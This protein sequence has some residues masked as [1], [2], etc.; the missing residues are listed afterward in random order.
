MEYE[1]V[2]GK[3]KHYSTRYY[4][5]FVGGQIVVSTRKRDLPRVDIHFRVSSRRTRKVVVGCPKHNRAELQYIGVS[6][7]FFDAM[8]AAKDCEEYNLLVRLFWAWPAAG[9]AILR[10]EKLNRLPQNSHSLAALAELPAE[11]LEKVLTDQARAELLA[12]LL[13]S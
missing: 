4:A 9:H 2:Y 1:I 7:F 11:I 13:K 6:P 12:H 8:K 3:Y 10:G 5:C